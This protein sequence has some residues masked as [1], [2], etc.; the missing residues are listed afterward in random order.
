MLVWLLGGC[1][2]GCVGIGYRGSHLEFPF[3]GFGGFTFDVHG[4]LT[5]GLVPPVVVQLT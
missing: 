4:L 1:G 5:D 2:V 3:Q